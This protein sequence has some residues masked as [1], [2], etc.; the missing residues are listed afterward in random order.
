[1][2]G[3]DEHGLGAALRP[4]IEAREAGAENPEQPD[5][6]AEQPLLGKIAKV[7]RKDVPR[8]PGRPKGARNKR[9]EELARYILGRYRDPLIGLADVVSTP[10]DALASALSCDKLEAAEFWR[11]C[12]GELLPY[13]HQRKPQALQVEGASAGMLMIVDLRDGGQG[14]GQAVASEFGL[15]MRIEQ[16]QG[17]SEDEAEKSHEGPSHGEGK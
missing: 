16:N 13:V 12:A 15:G 3:D 11:K 1:M 4:A 14:G 2:A 17:V 10:I 7:D 9:T 8:G 6:L 5:L